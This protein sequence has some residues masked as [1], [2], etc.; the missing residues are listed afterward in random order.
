MKRRCWDCVAF[1]WPLICLDEILKRDLSHNIF[2][3]LFVH[4][5]VI[6]CNDLVYK[7][8]SFEANA[9][10]NCS[11]WY[12]TECS[13]LFTLIAL[14]RHV[15]QLKDPKHRAYEACKRFCPHCNQECMK[16]DGRSEQMLHRHQLVHCLYHELYWRYQ[17]QLPSAWKCETM[18][19]WQR[20]W[21]SYHVWSLTVWGN[22]CTPFKSVHS[23]PKK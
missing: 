8:R 3:L 6:V 14:I 16:G 22:R 2:I 21:T 20:N 23:S 11:T 18:L 12:C 7:R 4:G 19:A 17:D 15:A 5:F 13:N 1:Y 9:A 10:A